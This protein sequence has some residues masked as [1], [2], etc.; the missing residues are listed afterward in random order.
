M[1]SPPN[2]PIVLYHYDLSPYGKRVV[3]YLHLRKIPY[4]QCIQPR[5]MPRPD[6][7]LLG[8]SYRRIPL[9]SIGR[10]VYLDTRLILQKLDAL[11]PPSAAHPGISGT[12]PEHAALE[13]LLSARP[14]SPRTP[15]S[16]ATAP[17]STGS[18]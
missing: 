7:S 15:R 13:H 12:S 1:A 9:L 4:S 6:V 11:Y 5:I 8:V 3:W 14:P 2:L 18:T 16:C 10:D 17:R